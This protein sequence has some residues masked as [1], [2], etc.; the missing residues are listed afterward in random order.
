MCI[1]SMLQRALGVHAKTLASVAGETVTY[2]RGDFS[3]EVVA[4]PGQ[5]VFD[6]FDSEGVRAETRT[7]DF[8]FSPDFLSG[9]HE[10]PESTMPAKGDQVIRANGDT[11]D[12][13]PG[14]SNSVWSWADAR[15]TQIRVHSVKR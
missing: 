10:L 11:Y 7:V 8:I 6:D 3:A 1:Q 13:F 4:I 14:A 2:R 15:E 9:L 5:S 12:A